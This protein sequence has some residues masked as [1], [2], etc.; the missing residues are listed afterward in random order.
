[1]TRQQAIRLYLD[2]SHQSATMIIRLMQWNPKLSVRGNSKAMKVQYD[3][4]R[5]MQQRFKL[6]CKYVGRGNGHKEI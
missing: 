4:L 3:V 1:M 2:N 6:K 5:Y